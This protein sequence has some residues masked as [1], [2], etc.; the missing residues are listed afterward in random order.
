[1]SVIVNGNTYLPSADGKIYGQYPLG[2]AISGGGS[3][4]SQGWNDGAS[5][6]TGTEYFVATTGNDGNAGTELSPFLTIAH[7]IS[8]LSAGDTLTVEDGTYTD[9]ITP[10]TATQSGTTNEPITVR[11]RT[12]GNVIIAPS[13]AVSA[14]SLYSSATE[15]ISGWTVD[16]FIC[17][18]NGEVRTINVNSQ[19]NIAIANMTNNIVIKRCGAFGSSNQDN[20]NVISVS[21][22]KDCLF[23]DIFA[24]GF[25]RK[26]MQAFGCTR[27]TIRRAV[28]RYDYWDGTAYKPNDPRNCIS[29]YNT[30]ESLFENL[31]VFDSADNPPSGPSS[32]RA[33]MIC[34][35]ND[36][37]VSVITG[38]EGNLCTGIISLNNVGNGFVNNGGT[39]DP[40]DNNRFEHIVSWGSKAGSGFNIQANSND[41]RITFCTAGNSTTPGSGFRQDPSPG[42]PITNQVLTNNYSVNNDIYGYYTQPSQTLLEEDNTAVSNGVGG[43]IEAANAPTL[44]S[45]IDPVYVVGKER[46]AKILNKTVDGVLTGD[47]L[48]PWPYED[49]IK[50]HMLNDTDL[51]ACSRTEGGV[52]VP[53]WKVA[54]N[55]TP[56]SL[57]E[58]IQGVAV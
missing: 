19:D 4:G 38:S 37:A 32:S 51:T 49:V 43:D 47:S 26:A 29:C 22:S 14:I 11:A 56:T 24:Y 18:T 6:G 36:T 57:T 35:G 5:I 52:G 16:G 13:A 1:M 15:Q 39:G 53:G 12:Y 45:I 20:N 30:L 17:R 42:L 41:S 46:G 23:E 55:I 28:L 48:W 50:T 21:R 31:I 33:G 10:A 44:N 54:D 25:G 40:T 7:A 9:P 8:Q 3:Y 58:Y 34:S 2:D 27:I